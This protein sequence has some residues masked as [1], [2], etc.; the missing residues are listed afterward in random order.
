LTKT[1]Q[2]TPSCAV[3]LLAFLQQLLKPLTSDEAT[4]WFPN[5]ELLFNTFRKIQLNVFIWNRFYEA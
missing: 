1:G 5:G 3:T 2:I 4:K